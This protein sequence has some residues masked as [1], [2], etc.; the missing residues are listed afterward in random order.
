MQNGPQGS[1]PS[2]TIYPRTLEESKTKMNKFTEDELIIMSHK[3]FGFVLRDRTWG[4]CTN[5]MMCPLL[6]PT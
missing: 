6:T 3:V 1:L 5:S 2:A 4:E